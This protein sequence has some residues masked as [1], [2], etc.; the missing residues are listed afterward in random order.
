MKRIYIVGL[1]VLLFMGLTACTD[2]LEIKPESE[3]ILNDYWQKQ[4]DVDA[5]IAACYVGL[6]DPAV[7]SHM[8]VWGEMRSDNMT[9][10]IPF[11]GDAQKVMDGDISPV[12]YAASWGSFYTVIN[13]CNTILHYAPDVVNRDDNF[14]EA[15]LKRVQAEVLTIR[16]LCYFYL[17]R[18][19]KDVPWIEQPSITDAQVYTVPKDSESVIIKHLIS[20]LTFAQQYIITDYGTKAAN[21]GRFTR[22]SV[23][24]LLAD[25]YLWSQD[26]QNCS[27]TCDLVLADSRIKLEDPSVSFPHIFY[28]GNSTESIFELQFYDSKSQSNS[29]IRDFYGRNTNTTTFGSL[30]GFPITLAYSE[31]YSASRGA[32][33]PFDF[34]VPGTNNLYEGA[35]DVRAKD[36]YELYGGKYYIFK[37]A[38]AMRLPGTS[39]VSTYVYNTSSTPNWVVYRLPDVMLM[40]AEALVQLSGDTLYELNNIANMKLAISLVNKTY[41]RSNV[42][43]DTLVYSYYATQDKMADLVLR[44]RQRELLFEG[45]RWF[46]L[47]RV[48]R[49]GYPAS[50]NGLSTLND[51]VSH[52]AS[53]STNVSSG[54]P[55]MD[56]LYFPISAYELKSN[57]ALK[58]NPFYETTSTSTR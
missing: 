7:I 21:H 49:R 9:E 26:Y 17:V 54:V 39:G 43:K 44:E 55:V 3:I 2:W 58:Q 42:G 13:Y 12:N 36:S 46:D 1:T 11:I 35:S 25:V 28:I 14:R 27:Q 8:I 6:G 23:N 34:P 18:A 45:K 51:K 41:M 33:S 40:K 5:A 47:V 10:G 37:Y 29:T 4:S 31:E 30:I 38:G 22:T 16:S 57:P 56:A 20:D 48:A 32:Y 19:F 53:A 15:D 52:K 24:A 50:T